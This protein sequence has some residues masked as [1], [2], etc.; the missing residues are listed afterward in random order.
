M[1]LANFAAGPLHALCDAFYAGDLAAARR[2]QLSLADINTAVTARFGVPGL[3]Y[4]MDRLGYY[5]G[6][7]RRPLLPLAAE[8][9]AEIDRLLDRLDLAPAV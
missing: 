7:A 1:A 6:P 3:K 5:G 2:I 9:R 8:G 4:T